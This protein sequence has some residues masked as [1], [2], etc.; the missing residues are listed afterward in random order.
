MLLRFIANTTKTEYSVGKARGPEESE[1]AQSVLEYITGD[2]LVEMFGADL[3][4]LLGL[5]TLP[6]VSTPTGRI[7]GLFPDVSPDRNRFNLRFNA[8]DDSEIACYSIDEMFKVNDN[9]RE[10]VDKNNVTSLLLLSSL[11]FNDSLISNDRIIINIRDQVAELAKKK[12]RDY[13][14]KD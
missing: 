3:N 8:Q 1:T 5:E 11:G 14:V 9:M 12:F 10:F 6:F 2:K 4:T 7:Y 13:V